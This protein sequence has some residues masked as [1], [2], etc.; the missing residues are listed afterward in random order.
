MSRIVVVGATG[1]IGTHLVPRLVRAGHEVVALSRG[2]QDPYQ[3]APEWDQVTRLT[4][5]RAA[6]D[7][8]GTFGA[9]IAELEAD[10]VVDLICFTADSAQQLVDALRPASPLLVHI[11][12]MWVHGPAARVPVTEDEPRTP[13]GEYGT[14]KAA[15]ELLLH[16]ETR[17]GGLR[18]VVVHPGHISGPG[19]DVINPLGNLDPRVWTWLATGQTIP[20]PDLGLGVLNHVHADD[21]AQVIERAIDTPEAVGESFHAV[22]AQAMTLRGLCCEVAGWFGREPQFEFVGWEEFADRVGQEHAD[23]TRD[24][25]GRS[26]AGSIEK[27][28][29]ILDHDPGHTTEATLHEALEWLVAAGRVDIGDS[30]LGAIS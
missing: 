27:A 16:E 5:D 15:I 10:V 1:H 20:I 2:Q 6:K 17:S 3:Q 8:A 24:H 28:R 22:A 21:V 18:S 9:R 4:C 13:Y 11:G 25:V 29:R 30:S 14:T 7:A 12:T 19:W 23:V 26:V